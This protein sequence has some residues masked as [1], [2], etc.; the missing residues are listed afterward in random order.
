MYVAVRS[1]L[2]V[3]TI[4]CGSARSS[5]GA[6]KCLQF[7]TGSPGCST[8]MEVL[9]LAA[10][11]YPDCSTTTMMMEMKLTMTYSKQPAVCIQ[12]HIMKTMKTA[13]IRKIQVK[14]RKVT[15]MM[16]QIIT[17]TQKKLEFNPDH[18]CTFKTYMTLIYNT[19]QTKQ[20]KVLPVYYMLKQKMIS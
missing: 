6:L 18:Y 1:L 14:T 12:I 2:K 17:R 4:F 20:K 3:L 7:L 16:M 10:L 13:N 9:T 15:V 5:C 8:I 19:S 11:C